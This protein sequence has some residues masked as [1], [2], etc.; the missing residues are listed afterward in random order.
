MKPQTF[1]SRLLF[2]C[3]V[4]A[5]ML[6]LPARVE[7]SRRGSG[8]DREAKSDNRVVLENGIT[9]LVYPVKGVE[10]V[11]VETLYRVGFLH[12]PKG[13]TQISHLIE[14]LVCQ[15]A[16]KSY[17]ACESLRLL[18]QSGMANAETLADFTH[19]DYV[20]PAQKLE[21]ALKIEAERLASLRIEPDV[22]RQEIPKCYRETDMV[23]ANPRAGMLKHA[24]MAFSQAWRHGMD[25]ALVRGGLA[26]VPIGELKQ[27]HKAYYRPGNLVVVL[28]GGVDREEGLRLVKKHLGPINEGETSTREAPDWTGIPKRT[29]VRWDSS[30]SAMCIGFAPPKAL[31]D[32]VLLS[33]WGNLLMQ[34]LMNDAEIKKSAA[35]VCT[36]NQTWSVGVLPFFVYATAK[37]GADLGKLERAVAGR[38][39]RI[40]AAK[41]TRTEMMQIRMMAN[42]LSQPPV[43]TREVV[44]Q[45]AALLAPRIGADPSKA[46]GMVLGNCA[47]QAGLRELMLGADGAR[48]VRR[49]QRLDA[50][51]LHRV[52][53]RHLDTKRR[54]VT[55]LT[56]KGPGKAPGKRRRRP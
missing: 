34:K 23:E 20:V 6:A 18:N 36:S 51:K 11:A 41:P 8:S 56:P 13:M 2:V 22:I 16:T 38:L 14:H 37:P 28:V 32:R 26:E 47:I 12:E 45:Q 10:Q 46:E 25:T 15:C 53:A 40:V 19:Y 39:E 24:F 17:G 43:L 50:D 29:R 48:R 7:S 3:S 52:L 49:I 27:F 5:V 31:S 42:A 9:V 35:M 4:V 33:L 21:L 55:V 30:T 44:R 1:R 54:F